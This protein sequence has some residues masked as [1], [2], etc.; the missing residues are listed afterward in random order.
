MEK[1]KT[2]FEIE[3][4]NEIERRLQLMEDPGYDMGVPFSKAN[5]IA[6]IGVIVLCVVLIGIGAN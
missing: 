3:M 2:E 6:A 1:K 4:E 5:W